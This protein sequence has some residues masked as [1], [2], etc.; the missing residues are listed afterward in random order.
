MKIISPVQGGGSMK[1][2]LLA[3]TVLSIIAIICAALWFIRGGVNS[4]GNRQSFEFI[5]VFDDI[6]F[7]NA[8]YR[9]NNDY[10]TF[11]L[12]AG[13]SP[14]VK[15]KDSLRLNGDTLGWTGLH[16]AAFKGNI[17]LMK[18]FLNKGV[19]V[20]SKDDNAMNALHWAAFS[21]SREWVDYS[22]T[23]AFRH[24]EHEELKDYCVPI[25]MA[26]TE[27]HQVRSNE[28]PAVENTVY[29]DASALLIERGAE[30]NARDTFGQTPLH[31]AAYVGNAPLV[32][33]LLKKGADA[34][35]ADRNGRS[36]LH[37]A[38]RRDHQKV[39]QL[40]MARG[41]Q[42]N[43]KDIKGLTPLHLAVTRKENSGGTTRQLILQ[44]AAVNEVD[45][46]GWTPLFYARSI[47]TAKLLID[48][49]A[50]IM[51]KDKEGRALLHRLVCGNKNPTD[52]ASEDRT[53]LY[54]LKGILA[55]NESME[56]ELMDL[57]LERG[58]SIDERDVHGASALH[59]AL[60]FSRM[61]STISLIKRKANVNAKDTVKKTPFHY[62]A[63]KCSN[64]HVYDYG[65][66]NGNQIREIIVNVLL[67][68]GAD[69]NAKDIDGATPVDYAIWRGDKDVIALFEEKGGKPSMAL[70]A[71][72]QDAAESGDA[73][74]LRKMLDKNPKLI[75]SR[76]LRSTTLLHLAA[77]GGH[78]E[79]CSLITERGSEVNAK[80]NLQETPL[81]RAVEKGHY[82]VVQLLV[83]KGADIHCKNRFGDTIFRTIDRKHEILRYLIEKGEDSDLRANN[84]SY[85]TTLL[86][87]MAERGD[88][89]MV[90]LILTKGI[91]VNIR[92]MTGR[93][94][95]HHC[96][97]GGGKEGSNEMVSF[98]IS[99]GA[100]VNAQDDEG[101]TALHWACL[102]G[103]YETVKLLISKGADVNMR[104][105]DGLAPLHLVLSARIADLLIGHGADVNTRTRDGKTP[106]H[107]VRDDGCITLF[108]A[109]GADINAR[110]GC[111]ETPLFNVVREGHNE[112]ALRLISKGADV[113]AR[114]A[115]GSTPLLEA[116]KKH[117][118]DMIELLVS[119][120]ADVNARDGLGRT[121]LL[122]A[123][124][125]QNGKKTCDYLKA[126]GAVE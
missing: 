67:K 87:Q 93:T 80:D 73:G 44:G 7:F 41:A 10:I 119:H 115:F 79:C 92:D 28:L 98:L 97:S 100:I 109:S 54:E 5:P 33:F 30:V 94:P 120:G 46:D 106:L 37:L 29:C 65:S 39:V 123:G 84:H 118:R 23:G 3:V 58:I 85:G 53:Q 45:S 35:L 121:P 99:Q 113:N 88:I 116:V 105:E 75:H 110:S 18:M 64:I 108:V 66:G 71:A 31:I 27:Y 126:S 43:R 38:A 50:D 111:G 69:I 112:R 48:A 90:R 68:A 25:N 9:G 49:G 103:F 6:S 82:P 42:V 51:K 60:T 62:M 61:H 4:G 8:V 86:H 117:D 16:I 14:S 2:K 83:N 81:I 40:L 24:Y 20:D 19:P 74:E 63:E 15:E 77:E 96:A 70:P 47:D 52:L 72:A 1:L 22:I 91:D 55:S 17:P 36:P 11:F 89:E 76:G 114:S 78:L 122:L 59:Y 34:D 56:E 125:L 102:S 21:G 13:V 101:R 12:K 104:D 95:L 26:W 32:D 124:K 107:C 57:I